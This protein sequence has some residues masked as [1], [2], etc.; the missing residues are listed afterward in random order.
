MTYFEM[1]SRNSSG[2]TE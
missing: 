2:G 1:L